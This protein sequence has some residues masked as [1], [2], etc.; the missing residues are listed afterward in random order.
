MG[1]YELSFDLNCCLSTRG[2]FICLSDKVIWAEMIW[3]RF[4][5]Q[6]D[7]INKLQITVITFSW[8]QNEYF[9]VTVHCRCLRNDT[10]VL[11]I[12]V[13]VDVYGVWKSLHLTFLWYA[14]LLRFDIYRRSVVA[15]L[16]LFWT[17]Q[18]WCVSV[19]KP[20][21]GFGDVSCS[22]GA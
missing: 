2:N 21:S 13:S 1:K 9:V 19:N 22:H 5:L 14:K 6:V 20:K 15:M 17:C 12:F 4:Y 10:R 7:I 8:C 16:L 11:Q 18:C 3:V